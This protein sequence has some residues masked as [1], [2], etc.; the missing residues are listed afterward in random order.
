[1]NGGFSPARLGAES[2][3]GRLTGA[4][5]IKP[6]AR[7]KQ[8]QRLWPCDHLVD[9]IEG[10]RQRSGNL[11]FLIRTRFAPS[12]ITQPS[13]IRMAYFAPSPSPKPTIRRLQTPRSRFEWDG[14]RARYV[15]RPPGRM[16]LAVAGKCQLCTMTLDLWPSLDSHYEV[17]GSGFA[18]RRLGFEFGET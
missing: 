18:V 11:Q 5:M 14:T 7:P 8:H 13:N 2:V 12:Y 1:M 4:M 9:H 10:H 16:C 17:T 3:T 15:S 6:T